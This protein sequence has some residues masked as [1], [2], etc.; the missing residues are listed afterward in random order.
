MGLLDT[1][2]TLFA[3]G[4]A[5]VPEPRRLDGSSKEALARSLQQLL[6][7]DRGWITFAETR[8]LFSTMDDEYAFGEMDEE[9]KLKLASFTGDPAHRCDV[10]IMP[11]E[12]RVYFIRKSTG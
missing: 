10:D 4:S 2:K 6:R 3:P 7:G 12:H 11:T 1:I 8:R 5:W 9:G